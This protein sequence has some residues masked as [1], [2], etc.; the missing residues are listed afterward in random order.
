M[1]LKIFLDISW[2]WGISRGIIE[3]QSQGK[4]LSSFKGH[5][6][7]YWHNLG[8]FWTLLKQLLIIVPHL[9]ALSSQI[10]TVWHCRPAT[11]TWRRRLNMA[12][13]VAPWYIEQHLLHRNCSWKIHKSNPQPTHIDWLK[14]IYTRDSK[15]PKRTAVWGRVMI[16]D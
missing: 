13:G 3:H 6:L 15:I 14:S 1:S 8:W 4:S 12:S 10:S 2:S 9:R 5:S 11:S 16:S 7:P